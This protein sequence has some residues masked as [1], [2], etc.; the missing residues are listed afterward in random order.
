MG[1]NSRRRF[2]LNS[3]GLM[4]AG[5]VNL[6]ALNGSSPLLI[7]PKKG[8]LLT[9]TLGRTGMKVPVVSMGVMNSDNPAIV[10][11]AWNR[12][13]R[14]FDTAWVYQRGN[15]ERMLGKVLKE[16]GVK[17]DEVIISTKVLLGHGPNDIPAGEEAKRVFLERFQESLARLQMDYV[18]ILY[19]H[20][21]HTVEQINNP[22]I[23]E[24]FT[25]L[26]EEGKIKATG[27]SSHA[28]WPDLVTDAADRGFYDVLLLSYNYSMYQDQKSLDAL[29]YA[30]DKG[31]G[32]VAM[33]TQCQQN[34]YK[35]MLPADLQ[36]FYEGK[37]MHTA[38]L[39]WVMKHEMFATSVPGFTTFQQL[40]ED[41]QVA[42]SLDFS[43]EEKAFLTNQ[44]VM[45][46]IDSN[47]RFCG[48]CV[49]S[50]PKNADIPNLMR[51]H[52]Y[53]ASYGNIHMAGITG[54]AIQNGRGLDAC[55]GCREC[56]AGCVNNVPV[57]ERLEE[58]KIL[59]A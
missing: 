3:A 4:A 58:L 47:C 5:M 43:E 59:F 40:E 31:V 2:I 13:M 23:L 24:A 28:Y 50:C 51:T 15:N 57:T 34:W 37:V 36:K 21:M 19:F 41:M 14:Y 27:F 9:R 25:K 10:K 52:M 32:L 38:L 35:E 53:A 6:N 16:L 49:P 42:Y 8:K 20:D 26:K 7:K 55:A 44:Q 56:V 46:A 39:K 33:K 22:Y 48:K 12:G 30:H 18:D 1:N 29:K 54:R 17:R 11:E 45:A